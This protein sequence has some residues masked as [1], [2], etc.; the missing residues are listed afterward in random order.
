[1]ELVL[2]IVHD[3]RVHENFLPPFAPAIFMISRAI[4]PDS[5]F[6]SGTA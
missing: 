6:W 3:P 2:K 1:M 4:D 5:D